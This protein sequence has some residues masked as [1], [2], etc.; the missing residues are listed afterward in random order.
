M[1]VEWDLRGGGGVRAGGGGLK[2][3]GLLTGLHADH[4]SALYL[5]KFATDDSGEDPSTAAI[6]T[7]ST[8]GLSSRL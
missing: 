3:R 7:G 5:D 4:T 8:R 2:N 6:K 1:R